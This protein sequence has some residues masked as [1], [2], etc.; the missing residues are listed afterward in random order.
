MRPL[1]HVLA[2]TAC[3]SLAPAAQAEGDAEQGKLLAQTCMGCHGAPGMRN[4]YPGF[5]V[6]KLGGQHDFYVVRALKAFQDERRPHPTMQA[7]AAD[8]TEQEMA[9]I[10]AYF[11][12]LGEPASNDV[13]DDNPAQ[14]CAAC[15]NADGNSPSDPEATQGAPILAGQYPEY[16]VH[17][18]R[19]YKSGARQDP[20][21]NG[22]AAGLSESQMKT[23]SDF[24]YRQ[25]GLAAPNIAE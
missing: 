22:M 3:L 21:M 18:L 8:L 6:P 10:A 12:S 7:Q 16:L 14:Q 11:A 17:T 23:I 19:E 4:A 25:D 1:L 13:S 2:V 20:V 15:H 9:D 24:Y 5:R